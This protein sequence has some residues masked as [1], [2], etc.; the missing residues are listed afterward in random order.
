MLFLGNARSLVVNLKRCYYS[1]DWIISHRSIV[2]AEM[3]VKTAGIIVIG[4]EVLKGQVVDQNVNFLAKKLHLLGIK[5]CKVSIVPD[6]IEDIAKEVAEYS[7]K[8]DRVIT[9]GG[10]GPTH[11]DLTYEGIAAAFQDSL[12]LNEELMTYWSYFYKDPDGARKDTSRKMASIPK[13]AN[14]IYTEMPKSVI[15]VGKFPV[16]TVHNVCVFPGIPFYLRSIFNSLQGTYFVPS[17]VTFHVRHLYLNVDE[18][19]FTKELND[20]AKKFEKTVVFGS[21]PKVH[22]PE[23]KVVITI[24]SRQLPEVDAALCYLRGLLEPSFIVNECEILSES[25]SIT[26]ERLMLP[27]LDSSF[28]EKF[29]QSMQLMEKV[30]EDYKPNEVFLAFNGGK[31][32]TA[33]LHLAHTVRNKLEQNETAKQPPIAAVYFKPSKPIPEVETFI[34]KSAEKYSLNL[35]TEEGPI[36]E[37][38]ERLSKSEVGKNWKAVL[39]GT[40]K[41]DPHGKN[42]QHCQKTDAG[43]ANLIRV[44]PILDWSYTEVW[45]YLRN[46]SVSYC[47]LYDEGFTS[48]DNSGVCERNPSLR[49]T[50]ADGVVKYKPAYALEDESTER[51]GRR[52]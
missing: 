13:S 45:T 34:Y 40:R 33:L 11:D 17:G 51:S 16:V 27:C 46:F 19:V 12:A 39:M 10:I 15:S 14:V 50:D 2:R 25:W 31:D 35:I 42:L 30:Y 28:I 38:L 26:Q 7:L 41:T 23:F 32:C 36:K 52:S 43:W 20:A 22:N 6:I 21:Y 48:L 44:S 49:Y 4:D 47:S 29:K 8:Y 5:L 1:F 3:E 18:S 9:T 24:E 37:T